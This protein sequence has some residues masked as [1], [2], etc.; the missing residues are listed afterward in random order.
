LKSITDTGSGNYS[1]DNKQDNLSVLNRESNI[2]TS[3]PSP[4]S[5]GM[6]FQIQELRGESDILL[7]KSLYPPDSSGNRKLY[8]TFMSAFLI[9]IKN[10][11]DHELVLNLVFQH[12]VTLVRWVEIFRSDEIMFDKR[13]PQSDPI[14]PA[15][16][17][18]ALISEK[19][20]LSRGFISQRNF[21]S[22]FKK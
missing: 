21:F 14:I 18:C 19:V 9:E 11:A 6:S 3:I 20:E 4:D 16:G 2:S 10:I 8:W 5:P 1:L 12:N 15:L 22:P 17:T 13:F 7:I